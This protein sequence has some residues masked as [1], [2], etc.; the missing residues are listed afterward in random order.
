VKSTNEYEAAAELM[1]EAAD[2]ARVN[3]A[4]L[5]RRIGDTFVRRETRLQA[6][7]YVDGL[8]S[9]LPRKN[10]WTLAEYAGDRSP[11]RMQRLLNH[12]AWD[13]NAAAAA[14]HDFVVE[15]LADEFAVA[16]F[17]E[18][19]QE[20]KGTCTAGVKRQYAGCVGKVT[21]A[22]NIVYCTY[23]T[24]RGHAII[25]A[26]PYL[27]REWTDDEARR[28]RAGIDEAVT[29]K[30]K[31]QLARDLLADLHA[32]GVAPPWA[33]G[34][35][36]YGRDGALRKFCEDNDTGYVFEVPCSFRVQL[37]SGRN[38]R[39]D[40]AVRLLQ[41][42]AWNHRSA[43]PGSKGER[44]YAW[45]WLAT[46]SPRH[47]LLIRR[48]I[49]DPTELA[50]FFTWVPEGRPVILPTL[51][52]VAGMRW[53]VEE[54]FQT[55]KG[56]FGL[57]HSQ[58]RLYPALRRHIVLV[59]AALAICAVTASAMRAKTS[60]LPPEPASPD[61]RPPDDPGL[62]A[63]T[64]AEIKRLLNLVSRTWR[65]ATHHLH[66][67]WWRRRHQARARWHHQRTRLRRQA[68]TP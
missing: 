57:D 46:T 35:E 14:V 67:T 41:P 49:T 34:D 62:I 4:E 17:D 3:R 7:K 29:F 64:V 50:Y 58:V 61:D 38:I 15:Q 55:G 53:P 10:G 11:D 26:V 13:H 18:S 33:T 66:W 24:P 68:E 37:T 47:H 30:T 60:T 9:D 16:V 27:P 63:L 51:V 8:L 28:Q 20:K 22:I 31:P 43:G 2:L 5:L 25:G 48:S 45:A 19:A 52:K 42:D 54:D 56:H 23:A 40:Q 39:A 21:N 36:V 1:V 32:A 12:A 6:G 59:M 44:R 65:I